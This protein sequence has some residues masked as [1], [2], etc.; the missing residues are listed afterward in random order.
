MTAEL[1]R[2]GGPLAAAGLSAL[3]VVQPPRWRLAGLVALAVG[4]VLLVPLLVPSGQGAALAGVAV[5]G[6]VLAVAVA[7]LVRR[8]PWALAFLALLAVPARIP[9]T[10]GDTSASLLVALYVIVAGGGLALGWELARGQTEARELGRLAPALAALVLWL[11]LSLTWTDDLREGAVSLLFFVLPFGLLALLVARLPWRARPLRGLCWL[12]GGMAAA[13][14]A[15][16]IGQWVGHG[17]FW[18]GKV[19]VANAY[20]SFFRVNSVFYDP[21]IYGRFL[22]IGIVVALA[23]LMVRASPNCDL[24]LALGI[25]GVWVGLLFSFS[26][27]SFVALV[28]GVALLAVLVWRRRALV[29]VGI[30]AAVLIPIG[31]ALPQLGD[32]RDSLWGSSGAAV[33]DATSG[34]SKLVS[35]G[36]R[37][38][39]DHPVIGVGL[40]G[41][42]HAYGERL[43][44]GRK[45]PPSGASHTT[46]VTVAAEAGLAGLGLFAWFLAAAFVTAFRDTRGVRLARVTGV[47][48]GT[49]LAAIVVHSLFYN[50]FFEDPMTW[51]FAGLAALAAANR[52]REAADR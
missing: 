41:F 50:A 37:I 31:L 22:V 11:G 29:A 6:I 4:A 47:I 24:A 32:A 16:G 40:G 44:L 36:I 43:E 42:K 49:A 46:P 19:E 34:R 13:F 15:V 27:S 9:V 3:V 35:N 10:V 45:R 25:L 38:A 1:A 39:L 20:A 51:G 21:S 23:L 33:N 5:V 14:A 52:D 28:F 2:A 12:V 8:W 26:Q 30:T 17:V 18:N 7:V 48:S